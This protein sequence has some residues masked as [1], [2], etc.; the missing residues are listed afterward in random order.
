MQNVTVN[1]DLSFKSGAKVELT[2][3]QIEQVSEF[4]LNMLLGSAPKEKRTY[5]KRNKKRGWTVEEVEAVREAMKLP[6]GKPRHKA[7]KAIATKF[8]RTRGAVT[9]KAV[10][11]R[12][13]MPYQPITSLSDLLG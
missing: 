10:E 7:Y 11:I 12:A 3:Q 1:V 4:V 5:T 2:K 13:Q 9:Q 6:L 8:N